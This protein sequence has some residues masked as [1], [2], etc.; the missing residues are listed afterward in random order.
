MD[1]RFARSGHT[2]PASAHGSRRRRPR[3]LSEGTLMLRGASPKLAAAAR[4]GHRDLTGVVVAVS[5]TTAQAAPGHAVAAHPVPAAPPS[6]APPSRPAATSTCRSGSSR[7][8]SAPPARRR[9]IPP[10]QLKGADGLTGLVLL[11][12]Q[13]RRLDD[14]LGAGEGRHHAELQLRPLRAARDERQRQRRRLDAGRHPHSCRPAA[15]RLGDRQRLRRARST[16]APA[17]PRPS[18]CSSC[19]TTPTATSSSAPRTR[20]PAA[21]PRTRSPTCRSARSGATSSPSPAGTPS[22]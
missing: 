18:R 11:H 4:R 2:P 20:P 6:S 3:H 13:E 16:S 21:R 22:T 19:T 10:S 7:S 15:R 5:S 9:T 1:T 17:A 8:P 14:V 12:R